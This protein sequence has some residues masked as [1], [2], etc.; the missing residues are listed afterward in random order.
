[1]KLNELLL[2][3]AIAGAFGLI[4]LAVVLYGGCRG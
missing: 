3:A 4:A 2:Y 1:M